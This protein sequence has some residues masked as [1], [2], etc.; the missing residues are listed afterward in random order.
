MRRAIAADFA[1][2]PDRQVQVIVTLDERLRD[3]P[4]PWTIARIAK[5]DRGDR[6]RELARQADYTA[7]IAPETRG[8]LAT[9]TRDL[10]SVGARLLG[11]TAEAVELTGNKALLAGRLQALLIDTPPTRTINPS[12]GLPPMAD[13]PAILKPVDGA[14]SI[15]TYYVP[16]ADG[17]PAEA[18]EMTSAV[19]QP[20]V[21]GT[22]MS[23]SFLVDNGGRAW[24]LGI[25]TQQMAM[26]N[27]RFEYRGG[28]VPTLCRSVVPRLQCA[29]QGIPGLRGFVGIDFI[30]DR[31][32]RKA[33]VLEIN[34][35]P[36]T[37]CVALCRLLPR[38]RL[39][40]A[41]LAVCGE[42]GIDVA[43]LEG[44]ADHIARQPRLTFNA[45][46]EFTRP[47]DGAR[48]C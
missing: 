4:G 44:L 27:G 25:G 5:T 14:G 9:L 38:G 42:R 21:P 48:V 18:N 13:Y 26:E 10:E 17:L 2:V 7:V 6:V 8:T 31:A 41:W 43:I 45:R 39:A 37:S 40:E 46:G 12:A 30:W 29:V 32:A 1:L 47:K 36:T 35:R 34:P 28:T 24:L 23:A 15:D 11:S 20:F 16:D 19:L 22:P 33:S 3:D